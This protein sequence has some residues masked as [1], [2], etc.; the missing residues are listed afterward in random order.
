VEN[1]RV[2]L[3]FAEQTVAYATVCL[4]CGLRLKSILRSSC[5]IADTSAFNKYITEVK[6]GLQL[7]N[8]RV[9]HLAVVLS[10]V[11]HGALLF[12]LGGVSSAGK[13]PAAKASRMVY[14]QAN[15]NPPVESV[16]PEVK[17]PPEPPVE[18]EPLIRP[19]DTG[20]SKPVEK[21]EKKKIAKRSKSTK[22]SSTATQ[23]AAPLQQ[24][25]FASIVETQQSYILQALEKIEKQ[26]SYPMQARRRRVSGNVT[27]AI[28]VNSNGL[29][30]KLECRQGPASLCRAA[31]SAAEKAQPLP[32]LPEGTNH[33]AFEYQMLYKLH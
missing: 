29:I 9:I 3:L 13:R 11:A 16:Q 8:F 19:Q 1:H 24:A 25:S 28:Q 14:M 2:I 12:E 21:I 18:P 15:L 30:E 31:V 20:K 23:P 26:K 4:I 7:E 27:L 5:L 17:Q 33:L 32:A 6:S 22:P 10:V